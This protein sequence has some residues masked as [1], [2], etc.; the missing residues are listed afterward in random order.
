MNTH[1]LQ[2]AIDC[3][4][5]MKNIIGVFAADQIPQKKRLPPMALSLILI[6]TNS[7]ENT[8]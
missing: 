7:Q 4:V 6:H 8:G 1:Q 5:E 2:S 3:D